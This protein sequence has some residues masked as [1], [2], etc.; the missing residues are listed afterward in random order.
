MSPCTAGDTLIAFVTIGE[1]A[2]IAG[3]VATTPPGWERLYEHAPSDTSPS[4]ISPYQGWFA[5]P[6]C[7]GQT[8]A[9]FTISTPGS[10]ATSGSVVL[11][12]YS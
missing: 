11:S 12:E 2:A 9:T 10:G 7:S 1:Q 5:L 4:P 3:T 8:S 6:N